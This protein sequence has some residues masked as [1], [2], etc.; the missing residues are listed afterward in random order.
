MFEH[1]PLSRTL[2]QFEDRKAKHTLKRLAKVE[3]TLLTASKAHMKWQ[4]DKGIANVASVARPADNACVNNDSNIFYSN[5]YPNLSSVFI[6]AELVDSQPAAYLESS[7]TTDL[8]T[9]MHNRTGHGNLKMLIESSKSKGEGSK[10][11]RQAHSKIQSRRQA[12]VRR[13]RAGENYKTLIQQ[14]AQYS[15][16][17]AE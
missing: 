8:L 9:L 7:T 2:N 5:F 17:I 12:C 16:K 4:H 10:Y 13:V 14:A 3:P 1:H 11:R 6:T 15:W